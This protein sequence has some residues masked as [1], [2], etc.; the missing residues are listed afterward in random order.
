M[1][2]I[3]MKPNQWLIAPTL[4]LS[5]LTVLVSLIACA[6]SGIDLKHTGLTV[7]FAIL[8]CVNLVKCFLMGHLTEWDIFQ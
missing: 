5:F 3:K 6:Y 7:L 2:V 1:V 4:I 8:F